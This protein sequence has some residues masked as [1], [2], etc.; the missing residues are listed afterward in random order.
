MRAMLDVIIAGGG[1]AGA[2]L[3]TMLAGQGRSVML[4][5]KTTAAQDK[6]CGEFFSEEGVRYLAALGVDLRA[7][8]AVPIGAVRL[9]AREVLAECPLPF[10]GLSLPRRIVDEHLL[11]RAAESGVAVVRGT[12][13]EQL[14]GA[15]GEWSIRLSDGTEE[16]AKDAFLATGKHDLRGRKR[17]G[18]SQND[19][20]AFKMY[21]RLAAEQEERLRDWVELILFPGGY[22]GLQLAGSGCAN[23][24]LLL[25]KKSL[26]DCGAE[27][28]RVL[29][30]AVVSSAHLERR[31]AGAVQLRSRPITLSSIPY[32]YRR[33][34]SETEPW[35]LGDQSAVMPSFTGD[36]MSIA[37]HSAFLAADAYRR[38]VTAHTYQAILARQLKRPVRFAT[39][40]SRCMV[41]MPVLAHALRLY[42][43]AMAWIASWTRV[44]SH[45][46]KIGDSHRSSPYPS[47]HRCAGDI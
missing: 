8:G 17:T 4:F 26:R 47:F 20:V 9:A 36:G 2:A 19:L 1:P 5:E 23:L 12:S 32:G 6:M 29:A 3:G 34:S 40:L 37:L 22:A 18:G 31:L 14:T 33:I 10:A 30:H 24:S 45:F 15:P 44:P 38:G 27:W 42:P 46:L 25:T 7:L 43:G 35:Y 13:V 11:Q 21:F 39:A 28:S 16:T 41:S